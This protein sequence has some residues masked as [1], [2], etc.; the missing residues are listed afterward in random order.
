[1]N[2]NLLGVSLFFLIGVFIPQ[3]TFAAWWNPA[4]WFK[5]ETIVNQVPT[6]TVEVKAE[7]TKEISVEE[8]VETIKEVIKEV[9]VEKIVT[10]TETKFEYKDNPELIKQINT[11]KAKI[12]DLMSS[13][14]SLTTQLSQ[15]GVN[16]PVTPDPTV[17]S[18][19]L[20]PT[21]MG[22]IYKCQWE[23]ETKNCIP[24]N[25]NNSDHIY[26][27]GNCPSAEKLNAGFST[28]GFEVKRS[29]ISNPSKYELHW[30]NKG[31]CNMSVASYD[32]NSKKIGQ[33]DID[34]L[35]E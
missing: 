18:Q 6:S 32:S 13:N 20:I 27:S 14:A 2:K 33:F 23:S 16:E 34:F 19:N 17:G 15:C 31:Q 11:L 8:P 24:F 21:S 12:A 22:A 1:M 4:T 26:I 3:V 25:F 28:F 29:D 30:G 5:S 10:K 9:P 7:V 35:L